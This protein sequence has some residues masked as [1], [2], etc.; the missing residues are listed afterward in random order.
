MRTIARLHLR[1][2][3]R[4]DLEELVVLGVS[5]LL[6]N[7]LQHA[8]SDSCELLM[9]ETE[10]GVVVEVTDDCEALPVIN[11]PSEDGTS[12]RG[13]SMLSALAESLEF[14]PLRT[15]KRIRLTLLR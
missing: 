4:G 12:G 1:L 7:V 8:D 15:G 5:E 10:L 2:W 13:L 14:C 3:G 11:G 9:L 6:A